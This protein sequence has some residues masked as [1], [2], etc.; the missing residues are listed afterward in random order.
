MLGCTIVPQ[1][2]FQKSALISPNTLSL[3]GVTKKVVRQVQNDDT[4]KL[5]D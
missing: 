3:S 4:Q 2:F 1:H 5:L